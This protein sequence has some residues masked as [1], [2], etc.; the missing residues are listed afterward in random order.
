MSMWRR[1]IPGVLVLLAALPAAAEETVSFGRDIQPILSDRCYSCHGPDAAARKADLR[2][3]VESD[4]KIAAIVSGNPDASPLMQRILAT[5]PGEVMP[6]PAS[7]KP[8]L[9]AAEV[10]LFRQWIAGGAVWEGHWAF[11]PPER[12]EPPRPV[13]PGWTHNPIDQFVLTRLESEGLAPSPAAQRETLLR[14]VHFDITG[15]PPTP[16]EIDAFVLDNAPDAYER[17]VDR[18][19]DSPHYGER[20][21]IDWLDGARFADTNGFQNDFAR[22][23]H[24]WRDWVIRTFN[25]N[26]P[27][28]QFIIEQLAGDLL[29]AATDEQRIATGFCRNNRSNTEGGSV[30]EEWYVENRV[31]RVETVS[32]VFLGLTMGC[33]RCHD[34]KYDPVSQEEFYQFYGFFNSTADR[35]FYE[36]QR[37]NSG[38][39][40]SLPTFEHQLELARFDKERQDAETKLKEEEASAVPDFAAW[41]ERVAAA[42]PAELEAQPALRV[43][44]R[45]RLTAYAGRERSE[46]ESVAEPVWGTGLLGS[47]LVLSGA[48]ES[49]VSLGDAFTFDASK[50]FS[51]SAWVKPAGAG[52]LLGRMD[53]GNAARGVDLFIGETGDLA[54]HLV[55]AWPGNAIKA[56]TD[57]RL[58]NGVW[59]HVL[60]TYDGSGKAAGVKIYVGG[61]RADMRVETDTLTDTIATEVPLRIG[62]RSA[63]NHLKGEVAEVLLFDTELSRG[64]ATA[65]IDGALA[66]AFSSEADETRQAEALAF[67]KLAASYELNRYRRKIE[68]VDREKAD[69]VANV[70]PSVM[71][72]EELPEPN[73]T[74]LLTRGVYDQPDKTKPL[75]PGVPKVLPPLPA[76]APRNRMGLARWIA[77]GENPLTARVAMNRLWAKFFGNGIVKSVE[78]FGVQAEPPSHP[79]LLD[80]LATEFV[81]SGWDL[82][83]MHKLIAMSAAY[84]QDSR[85]TPELIERDPHNR[86]LARGPRFRLPAELVR[87]NALAASGL[88]A[89]KIGGPSVRPYQPEGLWDEL[90][91]GA[92]QGP[93]IQSTGDDLYRR[94]LYTYRKR[95]VPHPTLAIF[96]APSFEMCEVKRMQTNTPLQSLALLN[97]TTYVEAARHLAR[98]MMAEGGSAP[99]ARVEHGFRLATGRKPGPREME[100]LTSGLER[101]LQLYKAS[102][103]EAAAFLRHGDSAAQETVDEPV[104][105]AAYTALAGTLLNLD[106]TITKE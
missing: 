35:G 69:Y 20:M 12:V 32:A 105:L 42:T 100:L 88:L 36:E 94:S 62:G 25:A 26:M 44:L 106:E 2:L 87:D 84:R 101:Y 4:A 93:Y 96:N 86:L 21:A 68:Q 79:E 61:R 57:K 58:E 92:S 19:L 71:V 70:V 75:E 83:A 89:T 85:M 8:P 18:L 39:M 65:L 52:A 48:P 5:D 11:A 60:A 7:H 33:A 53:D 46:G 54:L 29:P 103:E 47:S 6:P 50:P 97:D 43:P 45:G 76:D 81:A 27:Y 102:P 77:S 23:M 98:R 1:G 99:A 95:T 17:V 3:D 80:W 34:H 14:R 63:S 38:P 67:A 66:R 22:D 9:S 56:A 104:P 74:Y 73:P 64:D 15:I 90:A 31:D 55:H 28:D 82:K 59:S 10:E 37:G 78:N 16:A 49:S 40:I 13:M 41:R 30:E 51:I 91:G 24:P 72:M